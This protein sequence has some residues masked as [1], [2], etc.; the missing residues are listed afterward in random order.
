M[1]AFQ[2]NVTI[3]DDN[4]KDLIR[5]KTMIG[6]FQDRAL[7][8]KEKREIRRRETKTILEEDFEPLET[9]AWTKSPPKR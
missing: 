8:D 9:R 6:Q 5:R 1:S 2:K 4:I 3:S 7:E